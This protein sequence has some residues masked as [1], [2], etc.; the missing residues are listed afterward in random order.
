MGV[1]AAAVVAALAIPTALLLDDP[2]EPQV[3]EPSPSP[4]VTPSPEETDTP[5]ESE[6]PA[7]TDTPGEATQVLPMPDPH[8]EYPVAR[9]CYDEEGELRMPVEGESV[10]RG[11]VK[12]WLCEATTWFAG[13]APREPL[14]TDVDRIV[15]AFEAL[16]DYVE[17]QQQCDIP[18]DQSAPQTVILEYPDGSLRTIHMDGDPCTPS[19]DGA[20]EK[21]NGEVMT[22]ELIQFWDAQREAMR[23]LDV[24]EPAEATECA[25]VST[26]MVLGRPADV[27]RARACVDRGTADLQRIDI[28]DALREAI[29]ADLEESGVERGS[30]DENRSLDEIVLTTKWGDEIVLTRSVDGTVY[31]YSAYDPE[32]EQFWVEMIWSPSTTELA[33]QVE[34]LFE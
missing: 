9:I 33:E 14:V 11:A 15:D 27:I 1:A 31:G 17:D 23:D 5:G 26:H 22:R 21:G 4:V 29:V 24:P 20:V 16:P 12:A 10:Q 19:T 32:I 28:P 8:P 6:S 2:R 30:L 34:A 18:L 7:V 3:A 13:G 25:G